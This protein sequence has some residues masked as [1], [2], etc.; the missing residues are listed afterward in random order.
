MADQVHIYSSV[1]RAS[2]VYVAAADDALILQT[3]QHQYYDFGISYPF[4]FWVI[5]DTIRCTLHRVCQ[6]CERVHGQWTRRAWDGFLL[7]YKCVNKVL[8]RIRRALTIH[9]AKMM[10]DR[11]H[12]RDRETGKHHSNAL[13]S[14]SGDHKTRINW[15]DAGFLVNNIFTSDVL[16]YGGLLRSPTNAYF[17]I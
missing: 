1:W 14:H 12:K 3:T 6:P 10:E 5:D 7:F 4:H 11:C 15:R 13:R 9:G 16:C 17:H 2:E 8:I